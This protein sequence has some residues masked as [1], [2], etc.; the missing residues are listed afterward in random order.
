V[1]D[2]DARQHILYGEWLYATHSVKYTHLPGWFVAY[3]LYDR[4]TQSFI[5]REA[6]SELLAATTIPHVPLVYA[7]SVESVEQL[8]ALVDGPSAF[9]HARREGVMVRVCKGDRLVSRA[10]LVRP[11][12]IAGNERWNKS[13]KLETNSLAPEAS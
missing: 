5:S 1:D 13:S 2:A 8:K 11:D 9:N 3:D 7:G 6:L 12:F 10:K 4:V